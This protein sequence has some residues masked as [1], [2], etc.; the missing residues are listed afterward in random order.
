MTKNTE[1]KELKPTSFIHRKD[2]YV[3]A[4][5]KEHPYV[6]KKGYVYYH[7]VVM[8]NYLKRFLKEN[9]IVHHVDENKSN[10]EIT[11]LKL[12]S[13]EEHT[14]KHALER[15]KHIVVLKYPNCGKIFTTPKNE[16]FLSKHTKYNATFCSRT[17]SGQFGF[18]VKT[19]GINKEIQDRLD[20][21]LIKE[22]ILYL[23]HAYSYKEN[24]DIK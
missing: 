1:W 24:I 21:C 22:E 8:E 13:R 4:M 20:N 10:N 14:N 12:M 5:I 6:N 7:R 2:G 18:Y 15:G 11:N 17:C 19:Y 16:S 23:D 9:E 3:L